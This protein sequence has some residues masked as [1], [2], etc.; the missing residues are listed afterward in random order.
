MLV[1]C[2]DHFIKQF[3]TIHK[4]N[5]ASAD[6]PALGPTELLTY[7][8]GGMHEIVPHSICHYTPR[9]ENLAAIKN[10]LQQTTLKK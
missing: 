7:A 6:L 10:N 2:E 3:V 5:N 1:G 9:P 4:L 8:P